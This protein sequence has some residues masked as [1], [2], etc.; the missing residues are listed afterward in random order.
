[1]KLIKKSVLALSIIRMTCLEDDIQKRKRDDSFETGWDS[2]KN[3]LLGEWIAPN[4]ENSCIY[5]LLLR[6]MIPFT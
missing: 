5:A 1:M 3:K 2:L 6:T 4:Q